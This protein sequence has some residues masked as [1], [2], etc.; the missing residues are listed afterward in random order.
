[1]PVYGCVWLHHTLQPIGLVRHEISGPFHKLGNIEIH[2]QH[3]CSWSDWRDKIEESSSIANSSAVIF[4]DDVMPQTRVPRNWPIGGFSPKR[5]SNAD[6]WHFLLLLII[7]KMLNSQ[8]NYRIVPIPRLSCD[9]IVICAFTYSI[10]WASI[11]REW[12]QTRTTIA[13]LP[14][15]IINEDKGFYVDGH[16]RSLSLLYVFIS[17][18][19]LEHKLMDN[20]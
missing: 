19:Y 16:V 1:M 15:E 8:L 13:V 6:H 5:A 4:Y 11:D 12:V 7:K 9:V 14:E 3:W 2:D 17:I 20:E 10:S 18:R